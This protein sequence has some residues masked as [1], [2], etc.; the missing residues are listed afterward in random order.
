MQ[1]ARRDGGD[2]NHSPPATLLEGP[3]PTL[4]STSDAGATD[5]RL[6]RD[7][8][9][10]SMERILQE[11]TAVGR[12]LEGMD[13]KILDLEESRSIRNDIGS[14]QDKVTNIDHRLSL[15]EDKLNSSPNRDH[16]LQYIRD[17]ITDLK[18]LGRRDNV[19]FFGH[20]G[21]SRR[22]GCQGLSY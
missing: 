1:M 22:Y 15:V 20:P 21:M 19:R 5:D 3:H 14:F 9:A 7:R 18:D 12:G 11:I 8:A 4:A 13:T 16:E 6:A 17:I 10:I 2:Q